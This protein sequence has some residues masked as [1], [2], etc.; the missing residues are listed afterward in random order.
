M[1]LYL[2]AG[3]FFTFF[4]IMFWITFAIIGF[5][6]FFGV[7]TTS[8]DVANQ[9]SSLAFILFFLYL[10]YFIVYDAMHPWFFWYVIYLNL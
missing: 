6:R 8:F 2:D 10:G 3:R 5:F 4:I 1:G 7:I 9:A